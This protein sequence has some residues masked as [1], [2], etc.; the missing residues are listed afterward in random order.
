MARL[1][2]L[3]AQSSECTDDIAVLSKSTLWGFGLDGFCP[4]VFRFA[5]F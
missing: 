1:L 4:V 2:A 3:A 5:V